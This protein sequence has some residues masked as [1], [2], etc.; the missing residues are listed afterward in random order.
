ML[1]ANC[2]HLV[3]LCSIKKIVVDQL[4]PGPLMAMLWVQVVASD[5]YA[6]SSGRPTNTKASDGYDVGTSGGR[7]SNTKASHIT[8]C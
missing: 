4:I 5:G 2:V 8:Y 1:L 3:E 7:P 6:I